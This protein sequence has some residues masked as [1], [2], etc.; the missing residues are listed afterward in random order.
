MTHEFGGTLAYA[1][2]EQVGGDPERI[3]VRTDVYSL[4]VILFEL[5]TGTYP[6]EVSG[7]ISEVVRHIEHAEPVR[8]SSLEP[9]IGYEAETII[10]KALSKEPERRYQSAGELARDVD[11]F[12]AGRPISAR[13]NSAWYLVR[14]LARRHKTG[15]VMGALVAALGVAA[16]GAAFVAQGQA[17]LAERQTSRAEGVRDGMER[18]LS[19]L[20]VGKNRVSARERFREVLDAGERE[21]EPAAAG[22]TGWEARVREQLAG[23]YWEIED[24]ARAEAQY[25]RIL[26][27]SGAPGAAAPITETAPLRI[28]LARLVLQGRARGRPRRQG[29]ARVRRGRARDGVLRH[30]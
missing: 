25:K 15:V 11:D 6:Y 30:G 29:R 19:S 21:V 18:I 1:S 14:K 5:L 10:L 3:D 2:P 27:I 12:L 26:E 22:D 20:Q 23:G 7:S 16:A 9:A 28:Q 4:G 13:S 8:P 17:A 24:Y